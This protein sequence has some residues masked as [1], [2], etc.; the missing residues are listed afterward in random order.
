MNTEEQEM[1]ASQTA[2]DDEAPVDLLLARQNLMKLG[3]YAAYSPLS[4]QYLSECIAY[5]LERAE[6]VLLRR[7]GYPSL[8]RH[9]QEILD[10]RRELARSRR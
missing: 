8:E 6:Q 5:E 7:M 2:M 3:M 4:A 10:T 9:R 1:P